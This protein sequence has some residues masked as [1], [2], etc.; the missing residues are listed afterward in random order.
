MSLRF[1]TALFSSAFICSSANALELKSTDISQNKPMA[2]AQ[3]YNQ[4]GCTG[5]NLSPAFSWKDAPEG[6]K[7]FALTAY[8]PDAPTG[9]GWWH[10]VVFDIPAKT[11]TLPSN[12]SHDGVIK[13]LGAVESRTDYGVAGFGGVCPPEGDKP[14][15]YHFTLYAL[16]VP[17]LDLKADSP[18]A[19]VGYFLNKHTL[20]KAEIVA[21]YQR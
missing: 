7:S 5:K 11:A 2:K 18:A 8:D 6:T 1:F 4:F 17:T 13:K 19:M 12:A 21:T 20:E 10:W 3:E 15:H 14:H 16:D 9:S